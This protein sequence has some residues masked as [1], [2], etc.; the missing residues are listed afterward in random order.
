MDARMGK[1][2]R[3]NGFSHTDRVVDDLEKLQLEADEMRAKLQ[4]SENRIA[5]Y[6][7]E[8]KKLLQDI[9]NMRKAQSS[10]ELEFESHQGLQ[11]DLDDLAG[12]NERLKEIIDELKHE[13]DE[14]RA[15]SHQER[16]PSLQTLDDELGPI[17]GEN[18]EPLFVGTHYRAMEEALEEKDNTITELK[19]KLDTLQAELNRLEEKLQ[20]SDAQESN[21][22]KENTKLARVLQ[23][24]RDELTKAQNDA[25]AAAALQSREGDCTNCMQMAQY[26]IDAE[27][28]V[29]QL[30]EQESIIEALSGGSYMRAILGRSRDTG[31]RGHSLLAMATIFAC[32]FAFFYIIVKIPGV[33]NPYPYGLQDTNPN[34]IGLE[35]KSRYWQNFFDY[36]HDLFGPDS[37]YI[38]PG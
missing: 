6:E 12:E 20:K 28:L 7:Q 10:L 14:A 26:Q 9:E 30:T 36:V 24:L 38:R 31:T 18:K 5:L 29:A 17:Q 35:V 13:L 11:H 25:A 37:A 33:R 15:R 16:R 8:K 19:I 2:R 22:A 34:L 27:R 32:S 21:L 4:L 3:E 1:I 23:Q